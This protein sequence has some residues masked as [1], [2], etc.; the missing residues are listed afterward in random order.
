M[1]KE[2]VVAYR[3]PKFLRLNIR[4]G[5]WEV[6]EVQIDVSKTPGFV[7]GLGHLQR[8]LALVVVVPQFG[9][10]EDVLTLD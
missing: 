8:M 7:L 9:G 4:K 6:N 3:V 10:D 1:T 5:N 2:M